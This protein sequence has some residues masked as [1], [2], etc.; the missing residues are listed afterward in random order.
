M[1]KYDE[2]MFADIRKKL[3]IIIRIIILRKNIQ[4]SLTQIENLNVHLNKWK[5]KILIMTKNKECESSYVH[6]YN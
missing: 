2:S 4:T 1:I 5:Y 3:T 6:E